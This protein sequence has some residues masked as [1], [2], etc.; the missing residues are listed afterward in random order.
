MKSYEN[1]RIWFIGLITEL[2]KRIIKFDIEKRNRNIK[3]KS[4]STMKII[5][6]YKFILD[7]WRSSYFQENFGNNL[8]NRNW[9]N[10][11]GFRFDYFF[12][13]N[14]LLTKFSFPTRYF[15]FKIDFQCR[16]HWEFEINSFNR[17]TWWFFHIFYTFWW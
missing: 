10:S 1:I 9:F 15:W 13:S 16:K 3:I 14:R 2:F 17:R 5:N 7:W 12:T 11:I 8:S 6:F 4:N